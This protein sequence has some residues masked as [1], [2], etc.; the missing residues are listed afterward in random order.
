MTSRN[1]KEKQVHMMEKQKLTGWNIAESARKA[2]SAFANSS[3]ILTNTISGT[4]NGLTGR[5]G[6]CRPTVAR[7][8]HTFLILAS[9]WKIRKTP[10]YKQKK[11]NM[12][13]TTQK[14][15]C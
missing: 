1:E 15:K 7:I 12:R 13:K 9:A 8:A 14:L 10:S 6:A 2:T 5:N 4:L 11:T 3:R